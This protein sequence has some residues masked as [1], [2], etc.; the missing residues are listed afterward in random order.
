MSTGVG[1]NGQ[2]PTF[3]AR[4]RRS[5]QMFRIAPAARKA[6]PATTSPREGARGAATMRGNWATIAISR[7]LGGRI[8]GRVS[9]SS[10]MMFLGRELRRQLTKRVGRGPHVPGVDASGKALQ[11]AAVDDANLP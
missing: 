1:L 8:A 10:V 6:T 5:A 4:K 11:D 7:P 9:V 3:F 2:T